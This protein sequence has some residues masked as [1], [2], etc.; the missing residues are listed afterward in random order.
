MNRRTILRTIGGATAAAG[1]T[2]GPASAWQNRITIKHVC[3]TVDK[4]ITYKV[5]VTGKIKP[6]REPT[7]DTTIADDYGWVKG[8]VAPGNKDTLKYSGEVQ[9]YRLSAPATVVVN[10]DPIDRAECPPATA[11]ASDD[12]DECPDCGTD[13]YCPLDNTVKI[14][15]NVETPGTTRFTIETT[16]VIELSDGERVD[17]CEGEVDPDKTYE[18]RYRY[19]GELTCLSVRGPGKAV[20]DQDTPCDG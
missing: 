14:V 2:A 18:K 11:T 15:A 3:D 13:D 16:G 20:I 6:T 1:L 8:E 4:P 9:T 12:G 19:S 17:R 10:G 7:A 5:H